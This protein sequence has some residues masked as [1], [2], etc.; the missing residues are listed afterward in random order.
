LEKRIKGGW[1]MT[2]KTKEEALELLK[3]KYNGTFEDGGIMYK[4]LWATFPDGYNKTYPGFAFLMGIKNI[5]TGIIKTVFAIHVFPS[6]EDASPSL[7]VD[8]ERLAQLE[9][10]W[11]NEVAKPIFE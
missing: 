6:G 1:K 5:K 3:N 4:R 9:I 8:K 11:D 7:S 2:I 10:D